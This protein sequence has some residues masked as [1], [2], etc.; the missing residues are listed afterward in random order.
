M[1]DIGLTMDAVMKDLLAD[2]E[3]DSFL[4]EHGWTAAG[5]IPS[6][7]DNIRFDIPFVASIKEPDGS[8]RNVHQ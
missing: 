5:P 7:P 2:N 8:S 6:E 4:R 1:E 3:L